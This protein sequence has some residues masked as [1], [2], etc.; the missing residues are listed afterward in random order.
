MNPILREHSETCLIIKLTKNYF[1]LP[2]LECII[3]NI[4]TELILVPNKNIDS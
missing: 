1:F 3:H 4:E 2:Y